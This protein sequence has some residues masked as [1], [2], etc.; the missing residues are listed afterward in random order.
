LSTTNIFVVHGR[1]VA[2]TQDL[3][4]WL[5]DRGASV[6]PIT[7]ESLAVRSESIP[8]EFERIATLGDAAI[9]LATPDDMGR[10]KTD[11]KFEPRARQNVWFELG[12]FRAR[13]GYKRTLMLIK[14][15][16]AIPSDLVGVLHWPYRDT[17]AEVSDKIQIFLDSLQSAGPEYTT[18]IVSAINTLPNRTRQ[19]L[20][21]FESAQKSTII[22]G[23]GMTN[24]RQNLPAMFS[25]MAK[26]GSPEKLV[27]LILERDFITRN[28]A[29]INQIY[30]PGLF[31][32][33]SAFERDLSVQLEENPPLAP[34]VS[35]H[36]YHGFLMFTATVA[37][38]PDYGSL[39]LVETLIK[40]GSS[41]LVDRPRLRIRWTK[42]FTYSMSTR[43][44]GH[45]NGIGLHSQL[46][47]AIYF[48]SPK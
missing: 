16:V 43:R 47:R 1:D 32:D 29:L 40:S 18:E 39:M 30:R 37:D 22:T 45:P 27:F 9:I 21:V 35:L 26:T 14:G 7:F 13:I 4:K 23:I 19:Y 31:D 46:I 11:R 8:Q 2:A 34:R 42:L 5:R 48:T 3:L 38:P 17:I 12:W 33:I 41:N 15:D 6:E 44:S 20:Q 24:V 10:L 36:R 28:E 25:R